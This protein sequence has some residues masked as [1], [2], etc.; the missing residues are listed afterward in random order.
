MGG[1]GK[2]TLVNSLRGLLASG[3]GATKTGPNE[4]TMEVGRYPRPDK[5]SPLSRIVWYDMPSVPTTPGGSDYFNAQ[6]LFIFDFIIVVLGD[7]LRT[8]ELDILASCKMYNIPS[9]SVRSKAD[10]HIQNTEN[11]RGCSREGAYRIYLDET[12]SI[13]KKELGSA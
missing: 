2:S 13:L 7:G 8:Q 9:F 3:P 5:E 1:T 6:G 10:I 4:A 12:R 11:G